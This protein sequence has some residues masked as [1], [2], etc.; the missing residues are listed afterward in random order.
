MSKPKYPVTTAIR[1]LRS[2]GVQWS[3]HLYEY[4][5]HGGTAVSARELGVE[6]HTVIKTLV[7]EDDQK[8]PMLVLMHG[9]R[10]VS[11]KNLARRLGVKTIQPCE[12]DVATRHTGYQFGGTSPFGTRKRLPVYMEQSI[13]DLPMIYINGGQRGY[14][15]GVDPAE[16]QRVTS[17]Q[18]VS[19]AI[20]E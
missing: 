11:T 6:E 9:D 20:V 13:L 2:A 4:E 7:M 16:V 1:A 8:Q 14:L 15:V 5:E 17:A 3:D 10:K 18:L 19:V 12:P